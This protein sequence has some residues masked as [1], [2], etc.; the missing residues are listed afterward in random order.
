MTFILFYSLERVAVKQPLGEEGGLKKQ[1]QF[2]LVPNDEFQSQ[3]SN[4]LVTSKIEFSNPP[5]LEFKVLHKS[6]IDL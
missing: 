4:L 6:Q 3:R 5:I 2:A 1:P